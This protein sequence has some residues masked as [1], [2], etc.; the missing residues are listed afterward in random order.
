MNAD[1]PEPPAI[2]RRDREFGSHP[3]VR[4][5]IS[6]TRFTVWAPNAESVSVLLDRN[7]WTPGQN[8]LN[9]SD[10]GVWSGFVPE[11]GFGETYKYAIKTKSGEILEK[12][13]PYAFASETPPK[14]AS[15]VYNLEGH[16]WKDADW[17]RR[18]QESKCFDEPISIYEVHLGS[19]KKPKDGRRYYT[20]RE[21]APMLIDY[22][23]SMGFTHLQL[24]PI[25][26]FPFDGSWGYQVTG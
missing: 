23:H 6:G 9:S 8:F 19:W 10:R 13:D 22:C 16:T 11:V 24:M 17:L 2:N 7:Y 21:L 15:I 18:R 12:S 26:E 14:T 5:G 25:T 20:Y 3:E 4:D 1:S